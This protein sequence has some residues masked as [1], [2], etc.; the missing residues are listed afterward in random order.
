[1]LLEPSL[2]IT[3]LSSASSILSSNE[4]SLSK[5]NSSSS[6]PCILILFLGFL[7]FASSRFLSPR[8][9]ELTF[10]LSRDSLLFLLPPGD[11]GMRESCGPELALRVSL[12]CLAASSSAAAS[13]SSRFFFAS[14]RFL[15]ASVRFKCKAINTKGGVGGNDSAITTCSSPLGDMVQ[16]AGQATSSSSASESPA[17]STTSTSCPVVA[18]TSILLRSLSCLLIPAT[19]TGPE[20]FFLSM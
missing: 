4:F 18:D 13:S 10:M 9:L 14:A 2:G 1:M 6:F 15:A 7:S 12:R 20:A 19:T 5:S 16:A 8:K 17:S 11:G 3:R